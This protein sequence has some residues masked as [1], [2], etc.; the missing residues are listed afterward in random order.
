MHVRPAPQGNFTHFKNRITRL[1]STIRNIGTGGIE[2]QDKI[3]RIRLTNAIGTSIALMVLLIAPIGIVFT[4]NAIIAIAAGIDILFTLSV[5]PLNHYKKHLTASL[6]VYFSQCLAVIAFGIILGG[7]IQLQCVIVFLISILYLLFKEKK[8]RIVCLVSAILTLVILQT[9]Y[10]LNSIVLQPLGLDTAYIIQSLALVGLLVLILVVSRPYVQSHDNNPE[11]ERAN[12]F[13]KFFTYKITHELRNELNQINLASHLIKKETATNKEL[14]NIG[15][16]ID[17]L[18]N[19]SNEAKNIVNNVLS[20]AKIE[21]GQMDLVV[22]SHFQTASFF[23]KFIAAYK[24]LARGRGIQVKLFI[25]EKMPAVIIGDTLKIGEIVNNLMGNAIKYSHKYSTVYLKI[26][27]SEKTYQIDVI[28]KGEIIPKEK[29]DQ[30][31]DPFITSKSNRQTEGTGLGLSLVKNI[32]ETLNGKVTVNNPMP[33]HTK[34]SVTLPLW[35]G[36]QEEIIEEEDAMDI[37]D[38]P[39]NILIVDDEDMNCVLLSRV[40]EDLGCIVKTASNGLEALNAIEKKLPDLIILDSA[41]PV[42]NGE[43]TLNK[44]KQDNRTK[45]IPVVIATGDA[46][47]ENQ[48]KLIAAGASAIMSKPIVI[49]DLAKV[50]TQHL[51]HHCDDQLK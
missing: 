20:M 9:I 29:L 14:E 13:I 43:E 41:M 4:R 18:R 48:A 45:N 49:K 50:L 39:H 3:K 42:L 24:L 34:F 16:L 19:S 8:L 38:F 6:V 37:F 30:I 26:T 22:L 35:A 23:E 31:F 11:L 10:Y 25:D 15:S 47:A 1:I 27:A 17:I 7:L 36:T 12:Q 44:L 5:L 46:F 21:S 28:S 32:A 40:L 33:E 2:D 51:K